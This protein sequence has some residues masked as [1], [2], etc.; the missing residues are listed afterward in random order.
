MGRYHFLVVR[1]VVKVL[2]V[3][4]A[5]VAILTPERFAWAQG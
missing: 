5:L 3:G 1:K 2:T 4:L